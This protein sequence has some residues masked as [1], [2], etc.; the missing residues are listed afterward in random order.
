MPGGR[1]EWD[2]YI[3]ETLVLASDA[4]AELPDHASDED[5]AA[6]MQGVFNMRAAYIYPAYQ[7]IEKDEKY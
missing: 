1:G 4:V 2:E 7:I 6:V 3:K 5:K